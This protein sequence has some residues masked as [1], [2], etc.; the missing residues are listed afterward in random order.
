MKRFIVVLLT[1]MLVL[2]AYSQEVSSVDGKTSKKLTKEQK[3]EKKLKEAEEIAKMVDTMV[4]NRQFVLEANYL[5]NKTGARINV[6]STINFIA[7]DSSEITIQLASMSGIGGSNGMGGITADGTISQYE[8]T[9]TGKDKSGYNIHI[10]AMTHVGTYDI[11]LYI[12][13]NGNTDATISGNT[14]GRLN[15]YGKLVPLQKSR[16]FKGMSI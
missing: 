1:S 5:S 11:F 12:S 13:P 10:L 14:S 6:N 15:Y 8:I 16:V 4:V 3:A 7:V 2:G 9:R